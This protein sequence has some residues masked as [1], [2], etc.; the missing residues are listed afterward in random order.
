MREI[1][2]RTWAFNK[3]QY[4]DNGGDVFIRINGETCICLDTGEWKKGYNVSFDKYNDII[5]MQ[6]TGLKDKNGKEIYEGDIINKDNNSPYSYEVFF[7]NGCF[8]VKTINY[9][10]KRLG[11]FVDIEVIGNIY[12]NTELLKQCLK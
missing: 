11:F 12:E 6:Y 2:F 7:D 3:M 4:P 1:K 10:L 5:L 9:G 8:F